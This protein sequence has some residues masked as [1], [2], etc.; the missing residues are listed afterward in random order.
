MAT[1]VLAV[2][3]LG[4]CN[5]GGTVTPDPT[6]TPPSTQASQTPTPAP[7]ASTPAPFATNTL[8]EDVALAW[9]ATA[10]E[11]AGEVGQRFSY[12]CPAGGEPSQV[13]GWDVYTSDSSVCG[14][15]MHVGL[16]TRETGGT[17]TVEIRE[18]QASYPGTD[19][20]EVSSAPYGVYTSSFVVVGP[21]DE[22]IT[23]GAPRG[24]VGVSWQA[25]AGGVEVGEQK[26]FDCLPGGTVSNVWGT[27]IYTFDSSVC[28]AAVHSGLIT[29]EEGGTVTIEVTP[30]AQE[31]IGSERNGVTSLDYPAYDPSFVFVT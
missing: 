26:D 18:G 13:W 1:A 29:V 28:T 27:D 4:A 23:T 17:V 3:A 21:D 31:Y 2:F 22:P 15:A 24:D 30:G 12:D 10:S 9:Q 20:F 7:T 8:A 6:A 11:Y 5:R 25:N 16:I 19:Q 14:A